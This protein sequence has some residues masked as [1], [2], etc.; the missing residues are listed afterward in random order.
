MVRDQATSIDSNSRNSTFGAPNPTPLLPFYIANL[1]HW[2]ASIVRRPQIL[3]I[4]QKS[5][6]Y[7]HNIDKNGR[8]GHIMQGVT[9]QDLKDADGLPFV[10]STGSE[11]RLCL[12]LFIDWF[13]SQGNYIGGKHK[14]T[15]AIYI[16]IL[17]LPKAQREAPENMFPIF[18]PGG[19]EPTTSELN[20]LLRPFVDE[21]I[22]LYETGMEVFISLHHCLIIRAML[23]IIIAD[24]PAIKKIGG[25]ASHA[26]EWFCHYNG[27]NL[28][29]IELKSSLD[30]SV[31]TRI[32]PAEHRKYSIA[33]RDAPTAEDQQKI[34]STTGFRYSELSRLPYL[35]LIKS[36][37]IEPMHTILLNTIQHHIRSTFGINARSDS[38][39][40][41]SENEEE[42]TQHT[43]NMVPSNT[44]SRREV[45]RVI[46]MLLR[47]GIDKRVLDTLFQLK[48]AS[49]QE[50]CE[51][52]FIP[53]WELPQYK[54][55][56]RKICMV[57][58][59]VHWVRIFII[60]VYEV[61][62]K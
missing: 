43:I 15:G 7:S 23:A 60:S 27:C 40:P 61:S 36:C 45:E 50:V 1:R 30:P 10:S 56:P 2:L 18:L 52:F 4:L 25:F 46:A 51:R 12:G 49:L 13:N 11:I 16:I 6:Q 42:D 9:V 53:T 41:L 48:T 37:I 39:F 20:H 44:Q 24:T 31:W 35:C 47:P 28:P 26:H 33:W 5:M 3:D 57:E 29:R 58:A 55:A 62:H 19:R 59:I 14:S 54:G 22:G 38:S 34:F 17:N 32:T 8:I 21:L